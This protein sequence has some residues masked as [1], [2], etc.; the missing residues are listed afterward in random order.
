[1]TEKLLV[2]GTGRRLEPSDRGE[3]DRILT[4]VEK[5][6]N[7]MRDLVKLVATSKLFLT[8]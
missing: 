5:S 3:V 4:D 2:Y 8:K 7:R 1:L 6:G